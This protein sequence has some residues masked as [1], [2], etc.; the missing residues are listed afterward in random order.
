MGN[1]LGNGLPGDRHA[2]RIPDACSSW[3]AIGKIDA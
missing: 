2:Q 1:V 3:R